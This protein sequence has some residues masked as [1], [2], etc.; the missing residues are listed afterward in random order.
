MIWATDGSSASRIWSLPTSMLRGS[1]VSRSRPRKVDRP[2]VGHRIGRADRDLDLLGGPLA[3][4]QVVL[5]SGEADDVDV[6]LVA[7]DPDAAGH[8]DPAQ[9]D[10]GHLRGAA[11]DIHDERPGRLRDRQAGAD[12][13]RH[14]LLDQSR[15]ARPGVAR[16]VLHGPLLDLGHS[17]RNAN[18]HARAGDAGIAVMH[19]LDEVAQHLLGDV[20]VADHPVAQRTDGH[21]VGR[22]APHHALRLGTDGQ[23]PLGAG[24]ERHHA[25]LGDHDPTV[26][27]RDQGV[28]GA[29]VDPD[30]V[31]Q[32]PE[33]AVEDAHGASNWV[34][35]SREADEELQ[36]G[37]WRWLKCDGSTCRGQ[38]EVAAVARSLWLERWSTS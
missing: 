31:R 12:G 24:V 8:H 35:G 19:L 18:Q 27:H 14:R 33:Q 13:G 34:C 1:P 21:D 22:R 37:G 23:H 16:G 15:P 25:R 32:Q 7:A 30:V 38:S 10:H 26:P 36:L 28:G 2:L 11:A 17:R 4:Q 6:H 5:P 9:A 3:H 29:Q 20:E